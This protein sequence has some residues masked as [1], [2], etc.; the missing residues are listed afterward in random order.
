[1]R[2]VLRQPSRLGRIKD[3]LILSIGFREGI[4]RTGRRSG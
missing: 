2:R 4:P 3:V 1:M